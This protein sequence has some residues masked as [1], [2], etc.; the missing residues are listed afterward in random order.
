MIS[1]VEVQEEDEEEE[2][3]MR[4]LGCFEDFVPVVAS[5]RIFHKADFRVFCVHVLAFRHLRSHSG[6]FCFWR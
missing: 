1:D 4:L 6:A 5:F 2:E 3:G